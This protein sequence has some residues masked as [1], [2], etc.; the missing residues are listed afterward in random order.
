MEAL[1]MSERKYQYHVYNEH[2]SFIVTVPLDTHEYAEG[3]AKR[4]AMD[5]Y[6]YTE[7]QL[8]HVNVE[9]MLEFWMESAINLKML[10]TK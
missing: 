8:E 10:N 5:F 4:V 1:H 6:E 3:F 2:M 9:R 7:E